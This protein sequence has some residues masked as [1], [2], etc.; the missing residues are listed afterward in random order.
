MQW[1]AVRWSH[2][3]K[4]CG[5]RWSVEDSPFTYSQQS[6]LQLE[7]WWP[8]IYIHT[9]TLRKSDSVAVARIADLSWKPCGFAVRWGSVKSH[10]KQEQTCLLVLLLSGSRLLLILL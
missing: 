10:S 7:A 3:Y 1:E 5:E 6:G 4:F 9:D 8:L 2:N